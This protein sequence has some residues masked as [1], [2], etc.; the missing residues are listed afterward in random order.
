MTPE[1]LRAKIYD[2]AINAGACIRVAARWADVAQRMAKTHKYLD[3]QPLVDKAIDRALKES[4][5]NCKQMAKPKP[6]KPDYGLYERLKKQ[7][8]VTANTQS[9][10]ERLIKQA[11]KLAGVQVV[12]VISCALRGINRFIAI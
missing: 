9:E 5:V 12:R 8:S 10:Y 4:E 6:K 11:I 1:E 2:G 3:I 7:A